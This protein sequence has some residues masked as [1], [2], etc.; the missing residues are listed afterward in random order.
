MTA[1]LSKPL[2]FRAAPSARHEKNTVC[3]Q[4]PLINRILKAKIPKIF[5]PAAR[6]RMTHNHEISIILSISEFGLLKQR[7]FTGEGG[8]LEVY[9]LIEP[10]IKK[11]RKRG[12]LLTEIATMHQMYFFETIL[13]V[14][15]LIHRN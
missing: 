2:F 5:A 14:V 11:N 6:S 4:N 8:L 13:H 10:F 15:V 12:V 7:G 1:K 3:R 9:R